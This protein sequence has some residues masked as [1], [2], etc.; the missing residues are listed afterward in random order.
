MTGTREFEF[1]L[2]TIQLKKLSVSGNILV[3]KSLC[4]D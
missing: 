4:M 1:T 3:E 2:G